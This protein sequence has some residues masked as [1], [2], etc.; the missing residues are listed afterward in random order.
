[1]SIAASRTLLSHFFKNSNKTYS[2]CLVNVRFK[3]EDADNKN[4]DSKDSN[5]IEMA[6][7]KK[8][9]EK[10][11]IESVDPPKRLQSTEVGY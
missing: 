5:K 10:L 9:S 8:F 4:H 7:L 6:V 1:M 3:S 11:H 2:K